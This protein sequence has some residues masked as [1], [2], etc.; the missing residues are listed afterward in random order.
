MNKLDKFLFK[1]EKKIREVVKKS[2]FLI[3]SGDFSTLDIKKLKGSQNRY[4][5][6]VGRVRIIFDQ[7]SIGNKIQDI[8][9]RDDN[10]YS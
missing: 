7:T 10:T 4:R 6:R 2:M 1:L 5:V 9:F 8:S 3:M